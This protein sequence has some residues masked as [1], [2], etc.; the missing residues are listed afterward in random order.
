MIERLF[1]ESERP[2]LKVWLLYSGVDSEILSLPTMQIAGLN[3]DLLA[4][5]LAFELD[6]LTG[7]AVGTR[8][9]AYQ[10]LSFD[11]DMS[12]FWISHLSTTVYDR[13]AD[14]IQ[15]ARSQLAGIAHPGGLPGPLGNSEMT[16]WLRVEQWSEIVFGLTPG[17]NDTVDLA[18]FRTSHPDELNRWLSDRLQPE[19]SERLFSGVMADILPAAEYHDIDLDLPDD[20]SNWLSHWAEQFSAKTV[21]PIPLLRPPPADHSLLITIAVTVAAVLICL[22]HFGWNSYRTSSY[23]QES[24]ELKKVEASM[25]G[26]NEQAN[27]SQTRRDEL[28]QQLA[29][30][31]RDLARIPDALVIIR[32]RPVQLLDALARSRPEDVVLE[33]INVSRDQ[34]IIH[35]VA[36]QAHLANRLATN[37]EPRLI[38]MGWQVNSPTKHDMKLFERGGPW[39][40]ELNL[41]DLGLQSPDQPDSSPEPPKTLNKRP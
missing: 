26:M 9:L 7:M 24:A 5:A 34:I 12:H 13:C 33:Q 27:Q 29:D 21:P 39:E 1:V 25:K 4:Q 17:K 3:D 32:Q 31:K 30:L 18:L 10:P 28:T 22:G 15:K 40:F 41:K 16:S 36:L 23:Q 6:A 37:L 19:R 38:K 35:G 20:R 14:V 11:E 2:G 8:T